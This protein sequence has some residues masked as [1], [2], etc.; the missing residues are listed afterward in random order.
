MA[1]L[2]YPYVC[3]SGGMSQFLK[4]EVTL[5]YSYRSTHIFFE[6]TPNINILLNSYLFAEEVVFTGKFAIWFAFSA[7]IIVYRGFNDQKMP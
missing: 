7:L 2:S 4:N 1:F 5:S 3:W 6:K